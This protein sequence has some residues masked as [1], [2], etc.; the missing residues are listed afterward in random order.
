MKRKSDVIIDAGG[1]GSRVLAKGKGMDD[2]GP[3][4]AGLH[5]W[6]GL[7]LPFSRESRLVSKIGQGVS[8]QHR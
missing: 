2:D 4:G 3:G 1:I 5:W 7:Q 6:P 8:R